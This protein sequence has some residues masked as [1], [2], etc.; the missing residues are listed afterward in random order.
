MQFRL[1]LARDIV[2]LGHFIAS[3]AL[4]VLRR[5][6]LM[7][8][9]RQ[10]YLTDKQVSAYS[11]EDFVDAGL[12]REETLLLEKLPLTSGRM[13]VLG[14]GGGRDAI[15]LARRGFQV[16]GADYIPAMVTEALKNAER[17]GV[18]L[19]G[20]VQDLTDLKMPPA[21]FDV[22]VL[23]AG[24]YSA[25]PGRQGRI[26]LL[27][28]VRDILTPRGYFLCQFFYEED[29]APRRWAEW[30]RRALAF[31]TRGYLTYERGDVLFGGREFLHFFTSRKEL[32]GEFAAAG[33]QVIDLYL[34]GNLSGA[35]LQAGAE[36]Q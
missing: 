28:R 24:M 2:R 19:E 22:V 13:L 9:T 1:K 18:A 10:N 17:C 6:D 25:I 34:S 16:V 32:A 20:V 29:Q 4:M 30:V 11:Q 15:A 7:E 31:L 14:M 21:S 36:V 12:N 26:A 8:Y 33:F 35:V 3:L 23:L 5:D 27:Q